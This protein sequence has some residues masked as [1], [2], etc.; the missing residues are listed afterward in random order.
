M[1]DGFQGRIVSSAEAITPNFDAL[2]R[3]G[4]TLSNCHCSLPTCSPSRASIMTGMYPHNHGV[5][6][7]EHVVAND[8]SVLREEYPHWASFLRNDGYD[9]AY[10]G[11]WHIERT[12]ELERFGWNVNGCDSN[13]SNRAIGA[14]VEHTG[15]LLE[16]ASPARYFPAENGYNEVLHYAVTPIEPDKRPFAATT[17]AAIQYLDA[18]SKADTPFACMVSFSEPNTPLISSR[19]TYELYDPDSL[20]LPRNFGDTFENAPGLYRRGR[21]VFSG[22]EEREWRELRTCYMAAVTE[23]DAQLGRLIECL[24]RNDALENTIVIVTGDH[25]RYVG[26]HGI[27]A[28]NFGVF[29]EIMNVPFICAGPGIS[30]TTSS[31]AHVSLVDLHATI[32]DFSN[33]AETERPVVDGAS[34]A[35]LLRDPAASEENYQ[36]ALAENFGTRFIVSQR[37]LWKRNYKLVFNGFDYDELY[38]LESDPYELNNLAMDPSYAKVHTD[39]M[40]ELWRELRR[41]NDRTL[42]ETHYPPMRIGVVGPNEI[43][44]AR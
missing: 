42:L 7:V 37:V 9:T 26:A 1:P 10:Y 3:R 36:Q 39:L 17:D 31:N 20:Q 34:F 14:G 12:E 15:S 5:L 30:S 6:Q 13:S 21:E 2:A 4:M 28:H 25:G 22:I 44:E 29:E 38:D 40:E 18:A 16:N 32:L 43:G 23:L 11:K 33:V 24:E 41:T 27:D 8:Q 35:P 19:S